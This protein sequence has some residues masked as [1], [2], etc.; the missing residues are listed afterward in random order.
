ML[1]VM[2]DEIILPKFNV[3]PEKLPKPKRKGSSSMLNFRDVIPTKLGRDFIPPKNNPLNKQ[4]GAF[5]F[6]AQ[7]EARWGVGHSDDSS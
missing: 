4:A 2:V 3:P 6:H 5:F 7:L 1:W